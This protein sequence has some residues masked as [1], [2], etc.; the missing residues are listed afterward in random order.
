MVWAKVNP[1]VNQYHPYFEAKKKESNEQ[2]MA[3]IN[4]NLFLIFS[5]FLRQCESLVTLLP[6]HPLRKSM[7]AP[8]CACSTCC[9]Y[10]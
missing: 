7:S 6:E 8:K 9:W 5:C 3:Q 1:Q 4:W 2:F 10:N